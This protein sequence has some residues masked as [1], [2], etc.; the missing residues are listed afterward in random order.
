MGVC[1]VVGM[2]VLTGIAFSCAAVWGDFDGWR[3][4]LLLFAW[5]TTSLGGTLAV[6][7]GQPK[8]WLSWNGNVWRVLSLIPSE[9]PQPSNI[10]CAMDVHLDLQKYLLVSVHSEF[11][12]RKWFWVSQSSF[13]DRWHGFRCAVYSRSESILFH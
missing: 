6:W 8:C 5:G 13:P 1:L 12:F 7:N 11:G 2:S 10:D 9:K 4:T 3:Y